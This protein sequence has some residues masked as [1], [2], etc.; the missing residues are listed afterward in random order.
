MSSSH[1]MNIRYRVDPK[2]L[3]KVKPIH[4]D[5]V[6]GQFHDVTDK[7]IARHEVLRDHAASEK[8]RFYRYLKQRVDADKFG[9]MQ[10]FQLSDGKMRPDSDIVKYIDPSTWFESKI[11]QALRLGLDKRPPTDILDIGTGPAHFPVVAEFYGHHVIGTDLPYRA[12]GKLERGHIYDALADIYK[13]K[14]IPLKIEA[15]APLPPLDR[16]YGLVT[17]FLA[18]FNMD[19]DRQPW[20]I[21]AWKFFLTDLRDNVLTDDGELYM[22][23]ADNKLTDEVWAYLSSLAVFTNNRAKQIHIVDFSGLDG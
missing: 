14:R 22:S 12:T 20:S 2:P 8:V 23:L 16:R 11:D 21:D 4:L 7:A 5:G 13:V 3:P 9:E 6:F 18:A 10:E 15:F 19:A 1:D 17:A